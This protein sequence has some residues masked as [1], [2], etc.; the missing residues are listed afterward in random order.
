MLK[1]Q[2]QWLLFAG[3]VVA[4]FTLFYFVPGVST[5]QR[6]AGVFLLAVV[7]TGALVRKLGN[8]PAR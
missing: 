3:Y 7:T 4:L 2:W 8:R 1:G 5:R 6:L